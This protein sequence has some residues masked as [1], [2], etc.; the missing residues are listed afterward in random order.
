M[1]NMAIVADKKKPD[2]ALAMSSEEKPPAFDP[3]ANGFSGALGRTLSPDISI[4][5]VSGR[6]LSALGFPVIEV[7][8]EKRGQRNLTSNRL[9]FQI[10]ASQHGARHLRVFARGQNGGLGQWLRLAT[11]N[12]IAEL[13]HEIQSAFASEADWISSLGRTRPKARKGK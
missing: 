1:T 7:S 12:T 13:A 4:I 2:V 8:L 9:S 10:S 6:K 5:N 3:N 11:P